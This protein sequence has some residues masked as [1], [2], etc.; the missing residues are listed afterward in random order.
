MAVG[1]LLEAVDILAGNNLA[2]EV[3]SLAVD[4]QA[5][6]SIEALNQHSQFLGLLL[7]LH[8]LAV[9]SWRRTCFQQSGS[10]HRVYNM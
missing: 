7:V 1:L 4:M 10:L 5:V 6:L 8:R 2:G 9:H 3:D